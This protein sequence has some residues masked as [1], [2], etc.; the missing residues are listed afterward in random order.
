MKKFK[1]IKLPYDKAE[2]EK[3]RRNFWN[4]RHGF[5]PNRGVV[6]LDKLSVDGGFNPSDRGKGVEELYSRIDFELLIADLPKKEKEAVRLK[7][8]EDL[9]REKIAE[10]MGIKGNAVKQLIFRGYKRIKERTAITN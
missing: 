3:Q 10:I 7:N 8:E 5:R 4:S 9:P 6:S 1:L 2:E